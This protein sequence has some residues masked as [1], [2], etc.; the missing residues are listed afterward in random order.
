MGGRSDRSKQ[1]LILSIKS[2]KLKM[3]RSVFFHFKFWAN[4]S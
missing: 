3:E 1:L 2:S 4:L